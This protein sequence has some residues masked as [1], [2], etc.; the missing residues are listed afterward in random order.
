MSFGISGSDPF[1]SYAS[2][3]D[4]GGSMGVYA[5]RRKKKNND[6][7]ENEKNSI[8]D[9]DDD[10]DNLELDMDDDFML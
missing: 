7:E 4:A 3:S 5:K 1:K 10:D 8:L 2:N 9:N 6:K